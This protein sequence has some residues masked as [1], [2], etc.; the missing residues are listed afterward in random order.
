MSGSGAR[1]NPALGDFRSLEEMRVMAARAQ[2]IPAQENSFRRLYLNQWTEQ[3]A[4]WMALP[5]WDACLEPADR[6]ALR[7]RP[8][9]V[10]MDLSSTQ[11]LTALVA[12]FPDA[13][14]SGSP[15]CALLRAQ[16]AGVRVGPPGSRPV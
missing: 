13:D 4:R 1:R 12:V 11:D 15:C 14:G 9:Y 8:C 16:A 10:G 3:A 7:G 5:Q 6:V 2:E